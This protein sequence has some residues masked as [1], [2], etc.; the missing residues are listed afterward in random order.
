MDTHWFTVAPFEVGLR[1]G[2]DRLVTGQLRGTTRWSA[3]LKW[4]ELPRR[5]DPVYRNCDPLANRPACPGVSG[6]WQ[7]ICSAGRIF[8]PS[9]SP[10]SAARDPLANSLRDEDGGLR[11]GDDLP[12]AGGFAD[13]VDQV[14]EAGRL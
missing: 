3:F 8:N 13:A 9:D 14:R 5:A 10:T 11:L 6:L 2:V 4:K 1:N 12:A 7:Q